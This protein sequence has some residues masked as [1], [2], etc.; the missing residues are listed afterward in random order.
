MGLTRGAVAEKGILKTVV[1]RLTWYCLQPTRLVGCFCLARMFHKLPSR[2]RGEECATGLPQGVGSEAYLNGTSQGPTPEDARKD[3]LICGRSR[4]FMKYRGEPG[5]FT[6]CL[7]LLRNE[8]DGCIRNRA[9]ASH[10]G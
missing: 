4:P 1:I 3:Y 6:N 9:Q 5:C 2:D 10:E 7:L 8:S